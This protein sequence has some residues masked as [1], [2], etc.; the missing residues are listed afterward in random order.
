MTDLVMLDDTDLSILATKVSRAQAIA[1][2]I[3]GSFQNWPEIVSKYAAS[4]KHLVSIDVV[5]EPSKGAQCLD[6]ERGDATV[7][8]APGWVETT[9]ANGRKARDLRWFPK[10]Y[11]Q[12]SNAAALVAELA[13]KG[14]QRADYRLWTA[15]YT[16]SAHICGK[17]SCG[18]EIEADATQWSNRYASLS[19]DINL[20]TPGFFDGPPSE[21]PVRPVEPK[22]V[23]KLGGVVLHG[24]LAEP[25]VTV[26]ESSDAG[27]TWLA[28]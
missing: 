18:C 12:E 28:A 6:V 26:V 24:S 11:I 2:Y 5:A 22:P 17:V 15:H 27:K 25:V 14:V 16:G 20:C 10:V 3:N 19:L 9:M 4:G 8:D 7:A 1:G 23:V 21:P 13:S